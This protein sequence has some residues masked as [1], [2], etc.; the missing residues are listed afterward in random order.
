VAD[1]LSATSRQVIPF[2]EME[3]AGGLA[4]GDPQGTAFAV[5]RL[6]VGASE[7]RDLTVEA[8][9]ASAYRSVGWKP[10]RV[11]DVLSGKANPYPA[12]YG[13]D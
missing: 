4:P 11:Q 9:R 13:V 10:V 12:L 8:W 1:Y 2:Y 3:K 6:A 5:E 7:L